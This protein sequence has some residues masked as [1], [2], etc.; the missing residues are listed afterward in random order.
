MIT[1]NKSDSEKWG[2]NAVLCLNNAPSFPALSPSKLFTAANKAELAENIDNAVPLWRLAAAATGYFPAY[3][4]LVYASLQRTKTIPAFAT[5]YLAKV[6]APALEENSVYFDELTKLKQSKWPKGLAE[7]VATTEQ[8]TKSSV[9]RLT[10]LS[11]LPQVSIIMPTYNRA[12]VILQAITT[13]LQ[14]YYSNWEL[15]VCD[16][17]S[18]DNTEALVTAIHDERIRYLKLPKRGAPAARNAGL[19]AAKGQV[20]AYLDSDNFW[21]PA[22]LLQ[23]LD[24]LLHNADC[25]ALYCHFIDYKRVRSTNKPS[26]VTTESNITDTTSKWLVRPYQQPEFCYEQLQ[27]KNF[28]D[29]NCFMHWRYL[30]EQL[31]GF[32]ETLTRRQD[33][34]LILRYCWVKA[35]VQLKQVLALY[36]RDEALRPI[37][38][39]F[40]HDNSCDLIIAQTLTSLKQ[41]NV[42]LTAVP[43]YLLIA[44]TITP[45]AAEQAKACAE[46]LSREARVTLLWLNSPRQRVWPEPQATYHQIHQVVATNAYQLQQATHWLNLL[47]TGAHILN[48]S[49]LPGAI[50]LNVLL[51]ERKQPV[52][53]VVSPQAG[54]PLTLLTQLS[55]YTGRVFT[56]CAAQLTQQADV[57]A[58]TSA[59]L[60]LQ[61]LALAWQQQQGKATPCLT[62][63]YE[64]LKQHTL[65]CQEFS[66]C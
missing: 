27:Q 38:Y 30:Y 8:H 43:D 57:T 39:E 2:S 11:Q 10:V 18:T 17:A 41:Q 65:S 51:L 61:Q 46:L 25:H 40:Q 63:Y 4:Q 35:P 50:W 44:D 16:D 59:Q 26:H 13:V 22:F 7:A 24:A 36:R 62:L 47:P 14:Q 53:S 5:D 34:E 60:L 37:T 52:L 54:Q 29:L 12:T 64:M 6:R 33:Y 45:A 56:F 15:L 23:M 9:A 31:G 20:I 28:I 55:A 32:N 48:F 58:M 21:H 1:A 66:P 49:D 3:C 42:D 19:A